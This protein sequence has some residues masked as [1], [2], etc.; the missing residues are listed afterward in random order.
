M[1]RFGSGLK[2]S[3]QITVR[4][5]KMVQAVGNQGAAVSSSGMDLI[6]EFGVISNFWQVWQNA[7][8]LSL[9]IEQMV[10]NCLVGDKALNK[11]YNF[12]V[13]IYFI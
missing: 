2:H 12:R 1:G 7:A 8:P 4:L 10:I 11:S 6:P 5:S 13:A 9:H 3:T